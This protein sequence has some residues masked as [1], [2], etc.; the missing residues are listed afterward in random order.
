MFIG[1]SSAASGCQGSAA[2]AD[3]QM[4]HAERN[5]EVQKRVEALEIHK[6]L[7]PETKKVTYQGR[8]RR[9][10]CYLLNF[11]TL[12]E[13]LKY[14]SALQLLGI[15]QSV[16]G[17]GSSITTSQLPVTKNRSTGVHTITLP[18]SSYNQ[19][20][21]D[22]EVTRQVLKYEEITQSSG[23][24]SQK[25]N[26]VIGNLN[27][28]PSLFDP[29]FRGWAGGV[30]YFAGLPYSLEALCGDSSRAADNILF[31]FKSSFK[32]LLENGGNLEERIISS[33]ESV[34][35]GMNEKYKSRDYY[36]REA[37]VT[38]LLPHLT[39]GS[40][41]MLD[42][43]CLAKLQTELLDVGSSLVQ[44][45]IKGKIPN[46]LFSNFENFKKILWNRFL[47]KVDG[48][49]SAIDPQLEQPNQLATFLE[50]EVFLPLG[51]S[52][53]SLR[54]CL[55][56]SRKELIELFKFTA[57]PKAG[58]SAD[59][60]AQRHLL[61]AF[62]AIK[63]EE[64]EKTLTEEEYAQFLE[65]FLAEAKKNRDYQTFVSKLGN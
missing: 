5:E 40:G 2:A 45:I 41:G 62:P 65:T 42:L 44:G 30:A 27:E 4:S 36:P 21:L 52:N 19:L 7:Q 50:N 46:D 43:Y 31:S 34:D 8:A 32:K 17:E 3:V 1:A 26:E 9:V 48:Y 59:K 16:S 15:G 29:I 39:K 55:E 28:N 37:L 61:S 22:F 47:I 35:Y 20:Q 18:E 58:D 38:Y 6:L 24:E 23:F 11:K 25:L 33:L 51:L 56:Q 60:K 64:R 63:E 13:A 10:S 14:S 12:D 49:S 54:G 57:D 53:E